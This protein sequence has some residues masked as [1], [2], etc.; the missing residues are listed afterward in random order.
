[1][2]IK[3]NRINFLAII[4]ILSVFQ[5]V[6][7]KQKNDY[8]VFENDLSKLLSDSSFT[9]EIGISR[10]RNKNS[11]LNKI[12]NK[13]SNK[14]SYKV[15]SNNEKSILN[16][17]YDPSKKYHSLI[18]YSDNTN[19][20]FN[21]ALNAIIGHHSTLICSLVVNKTPFI[22][23]PPESIYRDTESQVAKSQIAQSDSQK[24]TQPTTTPATKFSKN[25]YWDTLYFIESSAGKRL[26]RKRN[27]ARSCKWT[28]TPCGH[29]QLSVIALKDIGCT[30]LKCRSAREDY[31]KSLSMS[32]KLEKIN[33][34]RMKK[35]GYNLLPDYQRYL[36]HQQGATG[37]GKILDA[38]KG[39]KSLSKKTLRYMANNSPF[40][41]KKLKNAGSRGAAR[42]FLRYWKEKWSVKN[43]LLLASK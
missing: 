16:F 35:K 5:V 7:A 19:Y 37:L 11:A 10:S 34:K 29:H 12:S 41:Y 22:L 32:R 14:V 8:Q 20:A 24:N 40:S 36:V 33:I 2:S 1:M 4:L 23:Q 39:K 13:I 43:N 31:K 25:D 26:Y 17:K 15:S 9:N 6:N 30:S 3:Q 42:K 18:K 21:R 28:T 27:K 38:S